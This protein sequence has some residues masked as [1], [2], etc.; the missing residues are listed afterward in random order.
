MKFVYSIIILLA[1]GCTSEKEES[2]SISNPIHQKIVLDETDQFSGYYIAIEPKSKNIEGV[3]VLLPGFGQNAEDLFPETQ[4]EEYA[5]NNN[6]LSI[7]FAGKMKF[8]ADAEVTQKL[9]SVLE[10]V[11]KKF[12][13][14]KN[15][16]VFGG[17]SSG[18]IIALRYVELCKEFPSE[19]PINPQGIFMVDSPID[20]F[21]M[22]EMFETYQHSKSKPAA[23]EAKG[24][25]HYLSQAYGTPSENPEIYQQLTPFSMNEE[26][27]KNEI[28][29]KDVAVRSY[30][31]VDINWRL[32]NRNQSVKYQNF[33]PTS[34]LINRLMLLGNE[35]AEFM[36][37]FQ[38]GFRS[39]GRRH[40]HSWSIIEEDE[41]INW[42][43]K[44]VNG[45]SKSKY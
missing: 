3:L 39:D 40:P 17:Y 30:H 26:H 13:V 25:M 23:D 4:L 38:T 32:K 42:V 33:V 7:A 45:D 20:L 37:S 28:H 1:F 16:F 34:E 5:F 36:Q 29:L 6:L 22:W 14:S 11:L 9:T 35:R 31:D 15:Q 2:T 24:A 43:K 21:H 8:T 18:G 44:I 41:C 27:T 10:D 12:N 19:Y